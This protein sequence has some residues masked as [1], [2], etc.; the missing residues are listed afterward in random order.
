MVAPGKPTI[1]RVVFL[2]E[3]QAQIAK[4]KKGDTIRFRGTLT[5]GIGI[6]AVNRGW[7]VP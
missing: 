6:M 4:Y 5:S 7:I 2:D 3:Q 1:I